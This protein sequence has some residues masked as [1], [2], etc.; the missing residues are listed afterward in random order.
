MDYIM[1]L[2]ESG[3]TGNPKLKEK[4][5]NF[6]EQ[7]NYGLGAICIRKDKEEA[8]INNVLDLFS[9]YDS[10]LGR[11]KELKS[12]T[13]Y[14][15]NNELFCELTALLEKYD[16]I[17]YFDIISKKFNIVKYL[18]QYCLYPESIIDF[19]ESIRQEKVNFAT[20]AS[21]N[22]EDEQLQ[23]FIE[24]CQLETEYE[25]LREKY[26]EFLLNLKK[27]VVND[28]IL[29]R[30]EKGIEIFRDK[31]ITLDKLL[32]IE[33]Y[34]N[35]GRLMRLLPNIDSFNNVFT[36]VSALRLT[37]RDNVVL[38]HDIQEQFGKSY[39]RWVSESLKFGLTNVEKIE[40]VKSDDSIL[41]QVIDFL[42][43]N[44]MSLYENTIS[45]S[46]LKRRDRE[47]G[48]KVN[49][50][51]YNTNIISTKYD[52]DKFFSSHGIKYSNT[53]MPLND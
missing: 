41:I 14:W 22:I 36:S 34:T 6:R 39:E 33:D 13:E 38:Y 40:F 25:G 35:K 44:L 2:D 53:T 20:L 19:D 32:P 28:S 7:P 12:T 11:S 45:S 37:P 47:L 5:W 51:L 24:L 9:K 46:S 43:G 4:G 21:N 49:T 15:F 8:L 18:V 31:E 10:E 16:V 30:V 50:L 42:T 26:I 23:E 3:N 1:Y 27:N 48:K 29:E 52:Q 17:F